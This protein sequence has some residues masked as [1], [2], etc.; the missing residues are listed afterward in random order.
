MPTTLYLQDLHAAENAIGIT[1]S[2]F[3]VNFIAGYNQTIP[4]GNF[5]SIVQQLGAGHVRYPGG[6]VTEQYFSP[7]GQVWRDLF[8]EDQDFT[9]AEDGRLIEGPG[10]VFDFAT[11]NGLNVTFVIPTDSVVSMVNGRAVVDEQAV[12][13]I[14]ELVTDIMD[15][16]YGE[17]TIGSFEIGNEYYAFPDMTA[18]EYAA[19]A[20]EIIIVVDDAIQEHASENE[21]SDDWVSPEI[22]VQAGAGWLIGDNQ[23]I[24]NGLSEDALDAVTSVIT[25]YYPGD[26]AEVGMRD[27]H[28]GQISEWEDATGLRDLD[29]HISEWNVSGSD[30]GMAQASSMIS[31]FDE[32]LSHGV[33]TST[34]WGTQLRWLQSGLSVTIGDD[35]LEVPES[36]LSVGGEMMASMSESLFGLQSIDV[37]PD[38][39][40][41]VS[42]NRNHLVSYESGNYL[43]HVFGGEDRAVVYISSRSDEE[44][45]LDFDLAN[46]YGNPTH[47]WG[48]TLTSR[49]DLATGWRDESDPLSAY[50]VADFDGVTTYQINGL[51]PLTLEP[52][53][54]VRLNVQLSEEGVTI[55]DHDP[56][57]RSE[58]NYDDNMVGSRYN[59]TILAHIG[60]DSLVGRAGDDILRGGDDD[61]AVFGGDNDDALFGDDGNDFVR[62]DEGNDWLVG[63]SG[64]DRLVGSSGEDVISGGN[65]DDDIFGGTGED[66]LSAGQGENH[67]TGG[68][69]GDYF[70]IS[71]EG[72]TIVEDFNYLDG[73]R[74][75]F[76][77]QFENPEHLI[78]H[79]DTTGSVG[80]Q[81]G[82]IIVTGE[83]GNRTIFIGA[84][85]QQEQF[86]NSIVDFSVEGQNSILLAD[87]LNE[88]D[89]G[90]INTF[91]DSLDT[92]EFNDQF[93]SL[94]S[95][96]LFSN[97]N[98]EVGAELLNSFDQPE[99][100]DFFDSMGD[101]GLKLAIG[102]M[103]PE[104]LFTFFD[105]IDQSVIPELISE[106]GSEIVSAAILGMNHVRQ[107]AIGER[108]FPSEPEENEDDGDDA[109]EQSGQSDDGNEDHIPTAYPYVADDE[110]DEDEHEDEDED[111]SVFADCF[112]AT[113]AYESGD[114]PDV[115]LLRWYRD[116]VMRKSLF[117]RFAIILY[118]HLGPKIAEWVSRRPAVRHAFRA[119]IGQIVN[120]I[121]KVYR[122]KPGK[123][124]DQPFLFDS[125]KIKLRSAKRNASPN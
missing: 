75:T 24:I 99:L 79:I 72:H 64:N 68:E 47:V 93:G 45:N 11:R 118:W 60:E 117:G 113:V 36:R 63:G 4:E 101:Q 80:D 42:D 103:T 5:E 96:I 66:I 74:V 102:E 23:E 13:K 21:L 125:R 16:R 39:F 56:L 12:E 116:T 89:P 8:E 30:T 115:W 29:Y 14:H 69:G 70:V 76:L 50:G 124:I 40:V 121:S 43:V 98:A 59:D 77:G 112:I 10:R 37:N 91:V 95:V 87:T 15:G 97:L 18:E 82:D 100:E 123:Q 7:N 94:D 120:C 44:I 25:H 107:V 119:A 20:N 73:D 92:E 41:E 110:D 34:M 61:D 48:E 71:S 86:I 114:H 106:L 54:V 28:L 55:E 52:Y 105:G 67:T 111:S 33:D 51:E 84:A 17:V 31:G 58:L 32:M 108:F 83:G 27:R 6:T 26:L 1:G 104:E 9:Y 90:E 49:D 3:G 62:G 78:E 19:A 57:V 22:A 65:G 85:G 46:Y 122:R 81:P 2:H 53:E 109:Y 88:M 38:E 35:D